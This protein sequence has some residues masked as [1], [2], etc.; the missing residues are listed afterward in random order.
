MM[1]GITTYFAVQLEGKFKCYLKIT[2]GQLKIFVII[3]NHNT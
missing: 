3:Q 2:P 1:I